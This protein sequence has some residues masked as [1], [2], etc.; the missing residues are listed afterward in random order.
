MN[1]RLGAMAFIAALTAP[2]P[3]PSVADE[4]ARA[5]EVLAA[6]HGAPPVLCALAARTLQRRYGFEPWQPPGSLADTSAALA[7]ALARDRS[8]AAVPVLLG[9]L[10]DD[11]PCVQEIA[12]RLLAR[13]ESPVATTAALVALGAVSP[14]TRYAAAVALGLGDAS[15]A[16]DPLIARLG[17]DDA[18]VRAASAWALGGLD[19][20]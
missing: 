15:R 19:Q 1:G 17:D 8:D 14:G 13:I 7:W 9:G 16:L 11:D 6:A 2:A 5:R 12:A 10:R 3:A 18:T 20:V 4:A